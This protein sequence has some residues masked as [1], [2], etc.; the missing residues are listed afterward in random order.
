MIDGH[1]ILDIPTMIL[2]KRKQYLVSV[3]C[4][5]NSE[6]ASFIA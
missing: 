4:G 1:R 6:I 5:Y 3:I 2:R